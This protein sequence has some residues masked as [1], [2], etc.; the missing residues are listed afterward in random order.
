MF[1]LQSAA[2]G[3]L[4]S[5]VSM[6]DLLGEIGRHTDIH[7]EDMASF[8][9][10]KQ[11]LRHGLWVFHTT[12]SFEEDF[13]E[14]LQMIEG[15]GDCIESAV[16]GKL[17][18]SG[19]ILMKGLVKFKSIE[20]KEFVIKILSNENN[21]VCVEVTTNSAAEEELIQNDWDD[22]HELELSSDSS[23]RVRLV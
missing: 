4:L 7:V 10:E 22:I 1:C 3:A 15:L 5:S 9:Q 21:T 6:E 8:I 20:K 18:F 19:L 14:H 11:P 17:R 16:I 13:D 23:K 2:D 12:F